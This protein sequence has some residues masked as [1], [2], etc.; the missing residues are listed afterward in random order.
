MASGAA[1]CR[2]SPRV[3]GS[4]VEVSCVMGPSLG[5]AYA[6]RRASAGVA[7]LVTCFVLGYAAGRSPMAGIALIGLCG[8]LIL[9]AT[10]PQWTVWMAL[11]AAFVTLPESIPT[12]KL[13]GNIVIAASDVVV[14]LAIATLLTLRDRKP[15]PA[16]PWLYAFV[17]LVAVIVGY[18]NGNSLSW[19]YVEGRNV[20]MLVPGFVFASLV[21]GC[22]LTGQAIRAIGAVLWVSA[23]L[24]VV[25]AAT[26][27]KLHGRDSTVAGADGSMIEGGARRL[28]TATQTPALAVLIVLVVVTIIGRATFRWWLVMGTPA[29]V[30]V[31]FTFTRYSIGALALAAVIA[32]LLNLSQSAFRR[33][34]LFAVLGVGS[35]LLVQVVASSVFGGW[36]DDLLTAYGTRVVEGMT[37]GSDDSSWNSRL[38]ENVNLWAA[39]RDAPVFGNGFGYAYQ[40]QHGP[41]GSFTATF[42][43]YYAHNSYLWLVA[44][45]GVFGLVGFA[46]FA[47]LPIIRAVRTPTVE[48]KASAIVAIVLLATCVVAPAIETAPA[49]MVLGMAL[50]AAAAY[51]GRTGP[52]EGPYRCDA[53]AGSSELGYLRTP[54]SVV[55]AVPVRSW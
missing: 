4:Y 16:L 39:I 18:F 8:F 3:L 25:S 19:L 53:P 34:L 12:G 15:I 30:I 44:K 46:V 38:A 48:A 31:F 20:F 51:S 29:L 17:I 35:A 9:Y 36:A 23:G 24:V 27:L 22:G 14:I 45:S 13:V 37:L 54:S 50:G 43:P 21:I 32:A 40:R 42:G 6:A 7:I 52:A 41:Y 5:I 1:S 28:M 33:V 26:G 55:S 47:L 11:F 49:A 10:D 2:L